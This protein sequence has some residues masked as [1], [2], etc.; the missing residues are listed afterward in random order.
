[1]ERAQSARALFLLPPQVL[2]SPSEFSAEGF[3]RSRKLYSS[4]LVGEAGA[5]TSLSPVF[6]L[7]SFFLFR[8][9]LASA[10]LAT[11][12]SASRITIPSYR[13]SPLF[14]FPAFFCDTNRWR[15]FMYRL[16]SSCFFLLFFFFPLASRTPF[17][18]LFLGRKVPVEFFS[19]ILLFFLSV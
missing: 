12:F 17:D 8:L 2:S 10:P 19:F 1:V 3:S 18:A 5:L 7:F 16:F 15:D 14:F 11:R 4:R 9:I 6:D 13:K